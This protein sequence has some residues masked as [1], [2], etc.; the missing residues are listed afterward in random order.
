[1]TTGYDSA[2]TSIAF[3]LHPSKVNP[4]TL[5]YADRSVEYIVLLLSLGTAHAAVDIA[6]HVRLL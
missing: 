4:I 2:C 1:M 5:F 3:S 6:T